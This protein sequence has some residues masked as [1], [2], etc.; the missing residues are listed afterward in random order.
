[1]GEGGVG[2]KGAARLL[3]LKILAIHLFSVPFFI[4]VLLAQKNY[5]VV[6]V[7]NPTTIFSL[8]ILFVE[9]ILVTLYF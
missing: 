4:F 6:L 5:I 1:V 3:L 9:H 7:S 8:P 2:S